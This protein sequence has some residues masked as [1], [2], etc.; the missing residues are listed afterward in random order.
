MYT[1]LDT[2]QTLIAWKAFVDHQ[3]ILS[4]VNPLI[5]ASWR[6]CWA[7]LNPYKETAPKCLIPD[8]LLASQVAN[9]DLISISRPIME[10]I[11]QYIE[12]SETAIALVNS[13]GC[14]L[15]LLGDH[16]MVTQIEQFGI[17]T[18]S[19]ISEFEMGTN[20][21]ALALI[22][23]V[24][25]SVVGP[26]HYLQ[27]YHGLAET[28]APIFDLSG[29]PLGILGIINPY[30]GC[31]AHTLGVVVAGT[32][33]IEGIRQSDQLLA[34]QNQRLAQL[35]T[36]LAA[37][38]EGT[39]VWN[40]DRVLMHI[41]P[42]AAEI[43]GLPEHV[44][45]GR[46]IG[47]FIEYPKFLRQAVEKR[48]PLTDVEVII[49]VGD[50]PI[51]CLLSFRYVYNKNELSWIIC[52][53][54]QEKEL[55]QLVQRQLGTYTSLTTADLPGESPK[56]R[57]V[58]RFVKWAAS[59]QASILISG[60]RGT[61][62]NTFASVIHSESPR[63]DGPFLIFACS[64]VPS[65]LVVSELLGA[66]EGISNR[67]PGGRPSKFEL[68]HG[69]TIFFQDVD[70]LP[71]EAQ[72]VLINVIDLGI[73]Q[74][75]GSH[76][77]IPV[78]VRVIASTCANMTELI[79]K[80]SFRSDLFYRLSA[81]EISPPPLRERLEDLPLLVEKIAIRLSKQLNRPL[82]INPAVIEALRNYSWPGNLRELEAVL[83]RAA[84]QAGFSGMIGP[85][86][87]PDY[88]RNPPQKANESSDLQ[89]VRSLTE[90]EREAILQA[91]RECNGN[92]SEMARQLGIGRTTMWRR[93]KAFS[94][95]PDDY[96]M[97]NRK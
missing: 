44:M 87:L 10:D 69:G 35:N 52:T 6:R 21:F 11:Y 93:L 3:E 79:A 81:F 84:V 94:I 24:P 72:G 12:C 66:D 8:H 39:L 15:D 38:S 45:L 23:R 31:H 25:V 96:R 48:E 28:T 60:E 27:R 34:E 91:A 71:L 67:E 85:S 53:A 50:R 62:Q 14:I 90:L 49:K 75:L 20:A 65:E 18:G 7:R 22:E 70:A 80:G 54:R 29:R 63:R 4:G 82:V 47:E 74:R 97:N 83:G 78:D 95:V 68:A 58:R 51:N 56:M 61:G 64:S 43:L 5:A 42:T 16:E 32:R 76:R 88:I 55:R 17:S 86:H 41:N 1:P 73:V 36:I 77:P 57:R 40:A 26:E 33:A 19:I 30:Y 2:D 37:N 13:A 59:A 92:V 46:H 9:F 89:A